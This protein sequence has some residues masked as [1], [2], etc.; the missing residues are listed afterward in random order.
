MELPEVGYVRLYQIIGCRKRGIPPIIPVSAATW[1]N[2]VRSGRYP[3]S[4]KLTG[5]RATGW[6]VEDI[7]ALIAK[8][9][10]Q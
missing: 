5:A 1:W 10:T 8:G 6:R 7:R 9:V 2:G 3:A 4:V